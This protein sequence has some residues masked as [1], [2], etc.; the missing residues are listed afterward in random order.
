VIENDELPDADRLRNMFDG[1]SFR[2]VSI[3][4]VPGLYLTR[5]TNSK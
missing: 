5:A 3:E 2:D 1:H 4:D